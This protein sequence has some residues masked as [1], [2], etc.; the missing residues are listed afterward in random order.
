MARNCLVLCARLR[1]VVGI[2]TH[3]QTGLF[4]AERTT[5]GI[6]GKL[7]AVG[8]FLRRRKDVLSVNRP[9][10]MHDNSLAQVTSIDP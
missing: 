2:F 3:H 7:V 1:E 6:A 8:V 9:L 10:P 5:A 4:T